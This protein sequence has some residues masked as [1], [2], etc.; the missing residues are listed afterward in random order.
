T[1]EPHYLSKAKHYWDAGW[2][3]KDFFCNT[4]DAHQVFYWSFG[5]LTRWLSLAQVAWC[6]RLLTWALLAWAWRRLSVALVVGAGYAVLTA[7]LFI[8]MNDHFQ[9]AGEWIVGGVEAKGFAYVLVLVALEALVR[10][11][12]TACILWLGGA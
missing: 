7:G 8:A 3:A 6:G 9:M 12:W 5:W 11:R 1:N 10:G 4:S 2:C